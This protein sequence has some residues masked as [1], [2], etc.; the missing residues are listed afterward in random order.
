MTDYTAKLEETLAMIEQPRLPSVQDLKTLLED[1]GRTHGDYQQ[2]A[3]VSQQLKGL[4]RSVGSVEPLTPDMAES[5]DL[6]CSKIARI[7]SGNPNNRDHW[8]DIAGYAQLIA[9]RL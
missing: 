1:R 6:I 3:Y 9:R 5:L 8:D 2:T 7:L 4:I